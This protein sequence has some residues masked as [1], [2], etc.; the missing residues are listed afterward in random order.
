MT[1]A[2]F[3]RFPGARL[4]RPIM[5]PQASP[6]RSLLRTALEALAAWLLALACLVGIGW[7]LVPTLMDALAHEQRRL[8]AVEVAHDCAPP[9]E[10]E[11][12]HVVLVSREGRVA[13]DGCLYMGSRGTY[14]RTPHGMP[15][16]RP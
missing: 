14:R 8:R 3:L 2:R 13:V 5:P 15:E 6:R 16:P 4:P 12:L 1:R 10:H 11:R 7:L 9:T